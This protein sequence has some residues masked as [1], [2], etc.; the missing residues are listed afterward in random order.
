MTLQT[1]FVMPILVQKLALI[2][3]DDNIMSPKH[4]NKEERACV[5][6]NR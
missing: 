3:I 6:C 4:L 1:F 5:P 2:F